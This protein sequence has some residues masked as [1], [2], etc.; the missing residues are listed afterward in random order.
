MKVNLIDKHDVVKRQ[1]KEAVRLFFEQ[2]DAVV[3]HTIIAS[4]HQILIDLGKAKG[5]ESFVKN[6]QVLKGNEIQNFISLINYP[7][8]FFKHANRDATAK[9][10]IGPLEQFIQDFVMDAIVMLQRLCGDIP[11]EA[12]VY[13]MW[14][15]SKYPEYFDDC[16]DDSEIK[17]MQEQGLANWDFPTIC[18]FLTFCDV[19]NEV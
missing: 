5:I 2:R 16:P 3:I 19:V 14:F 12:K 1:I 15:V 13:W 6:T 7:Y 9:I 11:I 17:K 10:D 4:A 8:N 18:Q